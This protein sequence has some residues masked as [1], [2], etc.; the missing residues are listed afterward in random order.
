MGASQLQGSGVMLTGFGVNSTEGKA[1]EPITIPSPSVAR[2]VMGLWKHK[3]Y[4]GTTHW[5]V[6][7]LRYEVVKCRQK[8]ACQAKCHH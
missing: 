3:F 4:G 7:K 5:R 2:T 6:A 1:Q 8:Q